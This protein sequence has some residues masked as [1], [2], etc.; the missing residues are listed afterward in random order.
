MPHEAT[1]EHTETLNG[2]A[3]LGA[4]MR[5]KNTWTRQLS[6]SESSKHLTHVRPPTPDKPT[7][8]FD[9]DDSGDESMGSMAPVINNQ[10]EIRGAF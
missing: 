10:Q 7:H 2:E 1:V 5:S 4:H 6:N 8:N 3:Q 9:D